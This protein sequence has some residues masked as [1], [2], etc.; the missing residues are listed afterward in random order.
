MDLRPASTLINWHS[1]PLLRFL[2]L[3]RSRSYCGGLATDRPAGKSVTMGAPGEKH[4]RRRHSCASRAP[5]PSPPFR[6][7]YAAG[8]PRDRREP[9]KRIFAYPARRKEPFRS[10]SVPYS[11]QRPIAFAVGP[12]GRRM[13]RVPSHGSRDPLILDQHRPI[14]ELSGHELPCKR[15]RRAMPRPHDIGSIIDGRLGNPNTSRV[16]RPRRLDRPY[17]RY[18]RRHQIALS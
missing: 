10:L 1:K 9:M 5:C 15:I 3:S 8:A 18:D 16:L 14:H 4:S 17:H 13:K 12:V 7:R 2:E 6:L 11:A